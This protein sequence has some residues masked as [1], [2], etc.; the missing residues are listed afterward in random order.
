MFL[1]TGIVPACM[2]PGKKA[3]IY[4]G[5]SDYRI[6]IDPNA[7]EIDRKAAEELRHYLE[8]ITSA[9]IP[10]VDDGAFEG[11]RLIG[12]GSAG[13]ASGFPVE[14]DW[15][16][17]E[18]DGFAL[19]SHG[20]GLYIAGGNGRG[21]LNGVY[22]IL[23]EYLGCRKLS[24]DVCHIPKMETI[25][26]FEIDR[27]DVP[28]FTYRE[29]LMPD[30]YD[31]GYALWHKL[32]NAEDRKKA[33]GMY[34]HTFDDLVPPET[35]F[36]EHPEYFAE[37]N[38]ERTPD[39]QIC[40]T[41][42]EVFDLVVAGLKKRMAK[43]PD[44][45]YWSVSQN[46]TYN[47][48][49]CPGC[50]KLDETHGGHAGSLLRFVNDVARIFPEKTISTLAY[51]YTRAA[52]KGLEP[53]PN[54]N[55]MLCTIECNRSR[56]IAW[57]VEE[58]SFPHD[59]VDWGKLTDNI[60]LWD[61][62]VQFR[63]YIDPF[64]NLRVL[65][66]NIRF[67]ADN[68][69]K[70]MFQQGSGGSRSEFHELR[71]YIIAKLLWNPEADVETIIKDFT[72]HYYGKA[73]EAI[74]TYIDVMHDALEASGGELGIYGYPWDGVETY[75]TPKLIERYTALLDEAEAAVAGDPVL[76]KRVRFA[77]LPLEFAIL[78]I[79]K[80]NVTPE[81]SIFRD[82]GNGRRFNH[83][84]K[85]RLDRFVRDLKDAG[86]KNLEEH[87]TSPDAY[88]VAMMDF[89]DNGYM[90]HSAL[91]KTVELL[92]PHSEKY[93]VGGPRAL[94][95]GLKGTTDFH[96]NWM[97]F[98]G[99]SMEAVVDL[100]EARPVH[101]ISTDFVQDLMVWIFLP[102]EVEFLTS[103]DGQ[104]F[105]SLGKITRKNDEKRKGAFIET[106][107]SEIPVPEAR[108]IKVKTKNYKKCPGWH[109]GAGG[110]SWIFIDEIVVN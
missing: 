46:D 103:I 69:I 79:S 26:F 94:T 77:R 78:E 95:D 57:N 32:H 6:V 28:Q 81:L 5:A 35:Y 25:P 109:K 22:T 97:G 98:E 37:V 11:D 19:K 39:S 54:V 17:L 42:P 102:H 55:I 30:L 83:E 3:L 20:N 15:A 96:C 56:P 99:C 14:I 49:Q 107:K 75:L 91:G 61:Y 88:H 100:G 70:M 104:Q 21:S 23:E 93:P 51:Q 92:I 108:Y 38:G 2:V 60:Y 58:G 9:R 13:N 48:C 50:R 85:S 18:R 40:L 16:A 29:I 65:Q 34:V 87:G 101:G 82:E 43:R 8:A 68:H 76:S 110:L 12:I 27:T 73:A 53:E 63:N 71:T 64:P 10:I 1:L 41:N 66:P 7:T 90:N 74:R 24:K 33:W 86:I 52:P 105:T 89:F 45:L 31:D 72:D 67:F 4:H 44:A 59:I 62:V 36:E 80:R 106:F 84:M 47:P